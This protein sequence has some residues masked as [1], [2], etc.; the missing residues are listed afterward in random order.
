[1]LRKP[2]LDLHRLTDA[3]EK[4]QDFLLDYLD[5]IDDPGAKG[6]LSYKTALSCTGCHRPVD[7]TSSA[8]EW[9]GPNWSGFVS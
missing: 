8:V 2:F 4:V 6:R 5:Y 1:M 9:K 3:R 7:S